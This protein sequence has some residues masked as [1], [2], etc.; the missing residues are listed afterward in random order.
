VPWLARSVRCKRSN[1]ATPHTL[2]DIPLGHQLEVV[3]VGTRAA[4]RVWGD[5]GANSG[6][7][8]C[9]N[10]CS[11]QNTA[12]GSHQGGCNICN[13]FCGRLH[14]LRNVQGRGIG[15]IEAQVE[16]VKVVPSR[17]CACQL[18]CKENFHWACWEP[19]VRSPKVPRELNTPGVHNGLAVDGEARHD[20]RCDVAARRHVRNWPIYGAGAALLS[21]QESS[22]DAE[23]ANM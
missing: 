22:N 19:A 9:S 13:V 20:L 17:C 8:S 5:S 21:P 1:E 14:R 10:S 11:K 2:G 6:A 15:Q 4:L 12:H 23:G 16:A 18:L 3:I 7:N